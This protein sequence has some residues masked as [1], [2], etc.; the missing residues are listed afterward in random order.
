LYVRGCVANKPANWRAAHIEVTFFFVDCS[1]Q[2]QQLKAIHHHQVSAACQGDKNKEIHF[3]MANQEPEGR[4]LLNNEHAEENQMDG[5]DWE[6][7]STSAR[8]S[9]IRTAIYMQLLMVVAVYF[10]TYTEFRSGFNE[11]LQS[12][13]VT[14]DKVVSG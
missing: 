2:P 11:N 10:C 5:S 1:L 3:T 14:P 6:Q 9:S 8:S 13:W 7:P 12:W 4:S